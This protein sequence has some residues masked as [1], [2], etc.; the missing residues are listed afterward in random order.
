MP[1]SSSEGILEFC[2]SL[3]LMR[4]IHLDFREAV[5]W[6]GLY[7]PVALCCS[8]PHQPGTWSAFAALGAVTGSRP[9]ANIC[10]NQQGHTFHPFIKERNKVLILAGEGQYLHANVHNCSVTWD[11]LLHV[12]VVWF[13][14]FAF[15]IRNNPAAVCVGRQIWVNNEGLW[16]MTALIW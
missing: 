3:E 13:V 4:N 7:C 15:R 1:C 11:A 6:A 14:S 16:G 5:G 2:F 9:Q 8:T 10:T 12:L